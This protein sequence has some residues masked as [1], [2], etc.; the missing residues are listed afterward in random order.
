MFIYPALVSL[1]HGH[2]AGYVSVTGREILKG[3]AEGDYILA[4]IGGP[5]PVEIN[6][7]LV[8]LIP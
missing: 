8:T 4:D 6:K 1:P 2:V 5:E 3:R 7:Q